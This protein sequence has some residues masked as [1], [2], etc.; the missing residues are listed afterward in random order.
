MTGAPQKPLPV[1]SSGERGA[2]HPAE[3]VRNG[4][5][6]GIC[7]PRRVSHPPHPPLRRTFSHRE[8]VCRSPAAHNVDP[9]ASPWHLGV[10]GLSCVS[11]YLEPAVCN[12]E[13]GDSIPVVQPTVL[14]HFQRGALPHGRMAA[15]ETEFS[16]LTARGEADKLPGDC[17]VT[18]I[19]VDKVPRSSSAHFSRSWAGKQPDAGVGPAASARPRGW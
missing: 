19:S 5:M 3:S 14:R 8:K 9:P 7:R 6:R 16:L 18:R 17:P 2:S 12:Q 10:L 13:V 11:G 15:W 1:S 4:R